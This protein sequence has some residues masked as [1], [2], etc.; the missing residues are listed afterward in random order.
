MDEELVEQEFEQWFST[1]GLVTADRILNKYKISLKSKELL[2][3]MKTPSSFYR[4]LLQIALKNVLNGIVLQQAN[5]YNVYIQKLFVDY[6]LSGESSKDAESPGAGTRESLEEERKKLIGL[7][8]EL[9]QVQY[10]HENIIA[11]SQATLTTLV[12]EMS[13]HVEQVVDRLFTLLKSQGIEC[14]KSLVKEGIVNGLMYCGGD[15]LQSADSQEKFFEKM[16]EVMQ[17]HL[18][19]EIKEQGLDSLGQLFSITAN[20]YDQI[21][22]FIEQVNDSGAQ[23]QSLRQQFYDAAIYTIDLLRLLTDYK[24]DPNQDMINRESLIFDKSIGTEA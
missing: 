15:S 11:N 16:N 10:N 21:D 14:K 17:L 13:T 22:A 8:D 2:L 23:L 4:R 24:I 19:E 18:D 9:N 3:A 7:G 1:Y 5:D 6:M 12:Q 20:I